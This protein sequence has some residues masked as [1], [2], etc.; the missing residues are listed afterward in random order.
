VDDRGVRYRDLTRPLATIGWASFFGGGPPLAGVALAA[1][2]D[3]LRFNCVGFVAVI[4]LLLGL[5]DL[6]VASLGP[7][8][9][10]RR[11]LLV[12]LVATELVLSLAIAVPAVP[13]GPVTFAD[14]AIIWTWQLLLIVFMGEL[15]AHL[16]RPDLAAQWRRLTRAWLAC[17]A[18]G[19]AVGAGLLV[20]ARPDE[21][22]RGTDFRFNG[23]AVP[24][25]GPVAIAGVVALA[26]VSLALLVWV[27]RV[28]FRSMRFLRAMA[29]EQDPTVG[30]QGPVTDE[31]VAG[32]DSPR[33]GRRG[34]RTVYPVDPPDHHD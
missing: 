15:M 19:V 13:K 28:A 16:A 8:F 21:P 3:A 22:H 18:L 29:A 7:R 34:D 33:L 6:P 14:Q 1:D 31:L 5:R 30:D 20:L 26:A 11:N 24:I 25:D 9:R 2:S 4:A 12:G 17:G 32:A 10:A 23:T 27:I